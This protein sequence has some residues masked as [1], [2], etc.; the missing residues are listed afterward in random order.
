[1]KAYGKVGETGFGG[2]CSALVNL[3]LD[4]TLRM[5]SLLPNDLCHGRVPYTG[6]WQEVLLKN[7]T[8]TKDHLENRAFFCPV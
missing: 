3:R 2:R 1:M 8:N 6:S 7:K 5:P 4:P